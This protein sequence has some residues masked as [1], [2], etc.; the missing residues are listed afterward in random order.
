[1]SH[2]ATSPR[3]YQ[4]I[5]LLLPAFSPTFPS[6]RLAILFTGMLVYDM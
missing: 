5:T 6:R 2:T 3:H 1:M 4:T